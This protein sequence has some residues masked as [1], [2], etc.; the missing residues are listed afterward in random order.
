MLFSGLKDYFDRFGQTIYDVQNAFSAPPL[1]KGDKAEEAEREVTKWVP[2][3]ALPQRRQWRDRRL[4]ALAKL[5][6][7]IDNSSK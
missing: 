3:E 5:K 7:D 1:M 6:N 4:A 2:I